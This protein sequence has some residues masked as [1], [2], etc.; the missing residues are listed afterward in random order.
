M[1][2]KELISSCKKQDK[3]AQKQ[4]YEQY[5]QK[6]FLVC[7]KYCKN[8]AEAEDNLHDT[9]VEVFL[10]IKKFKFKGSFEGWMKRIAINKA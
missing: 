10:N 3:K 7:L 5:K 1:T 4:L 2:E 6:L 9:F 8:Q